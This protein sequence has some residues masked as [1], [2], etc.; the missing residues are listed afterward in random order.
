MNDAKVS[1][2]YWHEKNYL[3]IKLYNK[4]MVHAKEACPT[5]STITNWIRAL[6]RGE[7]IQGH[8]SGSKYL[9]D[10]KVNALVVV[11]LEESLFHFVRSLVNIIKI[12]PIICDDIYTPRVMLYEI[13][14]LFF[15]H[16]SRF[17]K[18][19]ESNRRSNWT[20]FSI[21][22]NIIINVTF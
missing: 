14:I 19:F 7:N 17:K 22:R 13:Y 4:L 8:A 6:I 12:F 15:I 20:K 5:Y 18:L 2:I 10:N 3:A 9:V 11:T 21:R 1:V 16:F